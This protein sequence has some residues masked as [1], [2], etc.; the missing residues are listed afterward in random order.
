[1]RQTVRI[2]TFYGIAVGVNWSVAL[3]LALFAWELAV[4]ILPTHSGH[5]DASDWVA[6]IIGAVVLLG[7]LL[8]HKVSH[9]LVARHNDVRVRSITLFVFGGVAQLEGRDQPLACDL[10]LDTGRPTRWWSNPASRDLATLGRSFPCFG[11]RVTGRPCLC[12][13]AHS[14]RRLGA[15]VHWQRHRPYGRL[16]SDSSSIPR[17]GEKRNMPR[18][19]AP[20]PT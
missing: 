14:V 19:S 18:P 16:S 13:N 12:R 20:W 15:F 2:G 1:M 6:G 4:Y 10:Q 5:A 9:P 8:A 17:P 7:S 3:I 11:D